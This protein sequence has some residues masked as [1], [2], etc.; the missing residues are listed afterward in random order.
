MKE[1]LKR[2]ASKASIQ[3]EAVHLLTNISDKSDAQLAARWKSRMLTDLQTKL[4][5][6]ERWED[7]KTCEKIYTEIKLWE[8]YDLEKPKT[9]QRLSWE[10]KEDMKAVEEARQVRKVRKAARSN[11]QRDLEDAKIQR[12]HFVQL[13]S[14][15]L[16][17]AVKKHDYTMAQTLHKKREALQGTPLIKDKSSC[18]RCLCGADIDSDDE[19]LLD[20][21]ADDAGTVDMVSESKLAMGERSHCVCASATTCACPK[22]IFGEE[23]LNEY[24]EC[25]MEVDTHDT[26][27]IDRDQFVHLM[28]IMNKKTDAGSTTAPE[29]LKREFLTLFESADMQTNSSG[30]LNFDDFC[31]FIHTGI[32]DSDVT[33]AAKL[34]FDALDKDND[35]HISSAEIVSFMAA[36]DAPGAPASE[37]TTEEQ[38]KLMIKE[39]ETYFGANQFDGQL[40]F[41]EFVEALQLS[42]KDDAKDAGPLPKSRLDWVKMRKKLRMA[43]TVGMLRGEAVMGYSS[44]VTHHHDKNHEIAAAKPRCIVLPNSVIRHSWDG[45]SMLFLVYLMCILP[46]RL[47]FDLQ[48]EHL[49]WMHII[50]LIMVRPG[51][52][53][54]WI[55]ANSLR[56]F[57]LCCCCCYCCCRRCCCCRSCCCCCGRSCCCRRC[58]R[59][60]CCG[61][62]RSRSRATATAAAAACD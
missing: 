26:N 44:D 8:S 32:Q 7:F 28:L 48:N 60:C 47:G 10:Y 51:I 57:L 24:R 30:H 46:I 15:G 33:E 11:D 45:V 40:S 27:R 38:A 43:Q 37:C 54:D 18:H 19:N 4:A 61:C 62:G 39:A 29:D 20:D 17:E 56:K 13:L 50:A 49:N 59:R 52:L 31:R 42:T 2:A 36:T 35:K 5:A 16:D 34:A 14:E 55:V 23:E 12:K 53:F 22:H 21:G 25:F 58:C 41:E 9:V 1:S 6:A 3:T